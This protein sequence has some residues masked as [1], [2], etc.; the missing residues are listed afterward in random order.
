MKLM[1][2]D[3]LGILLALLTFIVPAISAAF[4]KKRKKKQQVVQD[5]VPVE[6]EEAQDSIPDKSQEIEEMFNILL[7]LEKKMGVEG[8]AAEDMDN[9]LQDIEEEQPQ[10]VVEEMPQG[11]VGEELPEE[12]VATE[13]GIVATEQEPSACARQ[14]EPEQNRQ[15]LKEK[16]RTNPKDAVI[17]SEILNPKFKEY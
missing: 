7:G 6:E 10:D 2:S 5:E 13:E 4:E 1:D 9:E 14:D 8:D 16:F 17:M 15:S 12:V 11:V 3:L